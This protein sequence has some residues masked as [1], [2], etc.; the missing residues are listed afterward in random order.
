MRETNFKICSCSEQVF[1][2]EVI[3]QAPVTGT[4]NEFVMHMGD[5]YSLPKLV[6]DNIQ[7]TDLVTE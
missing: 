3:T 1:T 2:E 5:F 7:H 4:S 6:Q